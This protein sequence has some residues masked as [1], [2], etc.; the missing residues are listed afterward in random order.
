MQVTPVALAAA[1]TLAALP[2]WAASNAAPLRVQPAEIMDRQ[3]FERP[4]RAVTVMLPV[5]F[6]HAGEVAWRTAAGGCQ[7]PYQPQL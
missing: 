4:M 1:L 6:H 2:S 5:G 7:R 3:G